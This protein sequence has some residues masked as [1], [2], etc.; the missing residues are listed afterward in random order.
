MAQSISEMVGAT[1]APVALAKERATAHI[2]IH[3]PT[4]PARRA[5]A[6]G[7]PPPRAF[8]NLEHITSEGVPSSYA[9]YLNLPEGADPQQNR[10]L[11]AGLLP[12][13]G[14]QEASRTD[15]HY[16]G[17]GL[18]RVLDVTKIVAWLQEHGQWDPGH[19]HVTFVPRGEELSEVPL[20]V[21]QASLYYK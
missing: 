2:A 21:G 17:S 19:L 20:K 18:N 14:I 3:H 12:S 5:F 6:P 8:L 1:E 4:G 9:I 10:H 16:S 13:F 11:F 15:E 7:G